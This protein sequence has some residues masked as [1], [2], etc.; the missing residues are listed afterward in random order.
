MRTLIFEN[1]VKVFLKKMSKSSWLRD[2]SSKYDNCDNPK[3]EDK[4]IARLLKALVNL[5][6]CVNADLKK[7]PELKESREILKKSDFSCADADKVI[8]NI[9]KILK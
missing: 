9:Y 8:Q 7:C 1:N 5:L 3:R 4:A 6:V 2:L